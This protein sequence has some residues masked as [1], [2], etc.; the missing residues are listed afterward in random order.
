MSVTVNKPSSA[1]RTSPGFFANSLIAAAL[2]VGLS[3]L[4]ALLVLAISAAI[5]GRDPVITSTTV[6]LRAPGSDLVLLAQPVGSLALAFLLLVLF[7]GSKD[8]S[9]GRLVML[10]TMLFSFRNAA[11][12]MIDAAF[13]DGSAV[14]Q[15][16]DV[17]NAPSG[18]ALVVA[19]V[20]FVG[21]L[22][23]AVGAAAAFLSFSRHRTEVA[24]ARERLR[25]VSFIALLPG[26]AGP[27]LAVAFFLPADGSGFIRTLPL[28]GIFIVVTVF[29]AAVTKS[30][31]PPQVIEERTLSV[32]LVA[33]FA[34]VILLTRYGLG[35][36]IP[37]PPWD[38]Q[39]QL[40]WRP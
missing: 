29:A 21:L 28:A 33:A 23:V 27:L 20:G 15:A 12:A 8:R 10:W 32:G 31:V 40:T 2:G 14:A 26:L 34:L 3:H 30:F 7:P 17:W 35:P 25:F 11:V 6:T 22:L 37:V 16:L 18:V 38:D 24:S 13:D 36:G 4:F 5:A 9:S 1:I 19:I 39:L